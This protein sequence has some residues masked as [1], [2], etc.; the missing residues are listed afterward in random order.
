MPQTLT[1]NAI[2]DY[3]IL[4]TQNIGDTTIELWNKDALNNAIKIWMTLFQ[5]EIVRQPTVG[6]YLTTWIVKPMTED[7]TDEIRESLIFGLENGFNPAL[8]VQEISVKPD[9]QNR[10]WIIDVTVFSPDLKIQSELNL[11]IKNLV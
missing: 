2:F 6:G 5:G 4:G 9:F 11:E 3:D 10:K 8:K 7:N 1:S